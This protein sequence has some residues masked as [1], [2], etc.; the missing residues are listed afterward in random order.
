MRIT[1]KTIHNEV[2]TN[3][4]NSLQRLE[5]NYMKLS[6][7]KRI[8][9]PSD[10]PVGLVISMKLKNAIREGE[11]LKKNSETAAG[12]LNSSDDALNEL[13]KV[14]HRLKDRAVQGG[15]ETLPQESMVA[16]ADEVQQLREHLL[17]IAN[18]S[19]EG[20]YIFAGQQTTK[21]AYDSIGVYQGDLNPL[22]TDVGAETTMEISVPG[23][24]IFGG[25]AGDFLAQ[26]DEMEEHLR[27]GDYDAVRTIDLERIDA[28][29]DQVL[30]TRSQIGA[31]VNRLEM[32]IE[33]YELMDVNFKDLLSKNED[34]DIAEVTMNM[35]MKESVYQAALAT[36]ARIMKSTL[37]DYI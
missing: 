10:D 12:M 34:A 9:Y 17:H 2:I 13:T 1:N 20:R 21:P 3:I 4:Q 29:L 18:T 30:V 11:Q 37:V 32:A 8:N 24:L 26:L 5:E 22:T 35:M 6:T 7:G 27:D 36:S 23:E 25:A 16:L 31:K 28:R 14:L 33:R 19:F 15:N